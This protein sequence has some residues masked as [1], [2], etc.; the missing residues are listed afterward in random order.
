MLL[1]LSTKKKQKLINKN[2][3]KSKF[4]R[5]TKEILGESIRRTHNSP[6]VT[7]TQE[8]FEKILNRLY[9]LHGPDG[10]D[11]GETDPVMWLENEIN[12][13]T[14]AFIDMLLSEY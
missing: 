10:G 9:E 3:M 1:D 13:N 2:D 4:D 6:Y 7:I 5:L 11:E 12:N 14:D 8:A